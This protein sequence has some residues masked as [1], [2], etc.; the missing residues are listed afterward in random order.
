VLL[1]ITSGPSPGDPYFAPPPERPFAAEVGADPGRLRIGIMQRAPR[2]GE[3][4]ADNVAAVNAAGELLASLGHHVE[5]SYPEAMD[6][7]DVM[8]AFVKIV[9][10]CTAR[11][12]ERYSE[13]IGRS[14]GDADVEP[15]TAVMVANGRAGS[16]PG[17]V[18]SLERMHRHGRKLAAW[19]DSGFDLLLT[20]T[21]AAPPPILGSFAATPD[22]PSAGYLRA[23]PYGAFTAQFNLSGQPGIS[24]PLHW[25][26]DGLPIGIQLVAPYA[27]EDVLIRVAA[28]LEKAEPWAAK[29]PPLHAT[30]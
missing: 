1:D 20:P 3:P 18:A 27:R 8:I 26:A 21:C 5:P 14:I 23:A 2:D 30:R 25:N 29:L 9:A 24:L 10:A 16:G 13:K 22:Q 7:P 12:I 15:L 11:S 17:Y 28:Q 19:W 4:H 6:D